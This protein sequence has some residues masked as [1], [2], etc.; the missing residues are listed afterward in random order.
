MKVQS[1]YRIKLGGIYS[2]VEQYFQYVCLKIL[3]KDNHYSVR[4]EE[5][6]DKSGTR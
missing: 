6:F 4:W 1:A 2:L 3:I 5:R